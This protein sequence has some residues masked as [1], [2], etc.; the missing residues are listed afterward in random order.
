MK[1]NFTRSL[2][3]AAALLGSACNKALAYA[4]NF[5]NATDISGFT[6]YQSDDHSILNCTMQAGEPGLFW[7]DP[8]AG[9]TVWWKWTAPEDGFCTVDTLKET[10]AEHIRDTV[11]A[12]ATGQT[13]NALTLVA[14]SDDHWTSGN[15]ASH[16]GASCTFYAVKNTTYHIVV[17]GLSPSNITA[18]QHQMSMKLA[19]LPKRPTKKAGAWRIFGEPSLHGT[20]SFSKTSAYSFTAKFTVGQKSHSFAGV[21]SPEGFYSISFPRSAPAGSPPLAP[22]GLIIDAKDGGSFHVGYGGV[23]WSREDLLEVISFPAG[24]FSKVAGNFSGSFALDNNVAANGLVFATVKPNGTVTGTTTLPDGVKVTFSGPL[25]RYSGT[26][27]VLPVCATQQTGKGYFFQKLRFVELGQEDRM[28]SV[29]RVYYVRPPAPKSAF[30]TAGIDADGILEGGTYVKPLANQRALGFL[31]G[32]MGDGTLRIPMVAGEIANDVMEGL[33]LS[34]ANKFI[35]KTPAMR[36]PVLT[37]N[38]TTGLVTGSIYEPAGKKRT[39]TGALYK[40]NNQL[41]LKGQVA[42][43]TQNVSFEVTP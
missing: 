5:E 16:R 26:E 28:N 32:T 30:Y 27:S 9:K 29:G 25:T 6:R 14:F 42:G 12:V 31:N 11:I 18:T 33:N 34:I 3:L 19:L 41:F 23:E 35:F 36:K 2:F 17:D 4:D 24:T 1:S 40:H 22:L 7:G 43:T 15:G 8:G 38:T 39:I 13:V 21:L 10:E 20:L 37:L